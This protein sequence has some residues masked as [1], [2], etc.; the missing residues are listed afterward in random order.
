MLF[1]EIIVFCVEG[2]SHN[3]WK[4]S[5]QGSCRNVRTSVEVEN[6]FA[7]KLSTSYESAIQ[8]SAKGAE[9]LPY[10]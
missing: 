2:E 5:Q 10:I 8:K 4:N 1:L 7:V 6:G 9:G 3:L